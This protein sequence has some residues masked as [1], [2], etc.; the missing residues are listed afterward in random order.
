M[1]GHVRAGRAATQEGKIKE[2][3]EEE[4]SYIKGTELSL[5]YM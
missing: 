1:F 2:T 3:N 5:T 4:A